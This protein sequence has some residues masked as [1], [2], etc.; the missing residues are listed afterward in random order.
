MVS[1]QYWTGL[2][3]AHRTC[4]PNGP[5]GVHWGLLFVPQSEFTD[6]GCSC[7]EFGRNAGLRKG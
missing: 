7:V 3:G 1:Q 5:G 6:L 4:A 2:G